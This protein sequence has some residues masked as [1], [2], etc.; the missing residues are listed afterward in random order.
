MPPVNKL[1][2]FTLVQHFSLINSCA[3]KTYLTL[4][5]GT[6]LSCTNISHF[7]SFYIL[8]YL[9]HFNFMCFVLP[10]SFRRTAHLQSNCIWDRSSSSCCVVHGSPID[11]N[12]CI[13]R[14]L[15]SNWSL[16]HQKSW[17]DIPGSTLSAPFLL[18]GVSLGRT[19]HCTAFYTF[20]KSFNRRHITISQIL[21]ESVKI[22]W[23]YEFS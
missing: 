14:T 16:N 18:T 11:W 7:I 21:L 22:F 5:E 23:L 17:S 9:F 8:F 19:P 13:N 4:S 1:S 2:T 20:L 3:F 10:L 6:K 15:A 12:P